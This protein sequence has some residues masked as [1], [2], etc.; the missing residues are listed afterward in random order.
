MG[1]RFELIQHIVTLVMVVIVIVMVILHFLGFKY[2]IVTTNSMEPTINPGDFVVIKPVDGNITKGEIIL[3][4][5]TFPDGKS[6]LILHRVF[7]VVRDGNRT[8]FMTKGDNRP[9]PDGWLIPR[10][11]V[12]GVYCFKI[13]YFGKLIIMFIHMV[14][15][16]S[17]FILGVIWYIGVKEILRVI[18]LSHRITEVKKLKSVRVCEVSRRKKVRVKYLRP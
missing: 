16:F 13:P 10:Q 5:F 18:R 15:I 12:I 14:I 4:R 8:Y 11:N 3:F 2:A 6:Y 1:S 7:R 9:F 17:P